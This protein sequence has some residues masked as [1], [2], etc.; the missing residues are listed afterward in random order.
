MW[1]F[2]VKSRSGV[3][4][5]IPNCN[6]PIVAH[7]IGTMLT[8]NLVEIFHFIYANERALYVANIS[9]DAIVGC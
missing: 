5:A 9:R 1:N 4:I 8:I 2:T 7:F 3:D 6:S